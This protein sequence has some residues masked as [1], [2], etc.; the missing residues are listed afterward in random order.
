MFESILKIQSIVVKNFSF[1]GSFN[2]G[3]SILVID[4]S[5]LILYTINCNR[6]KL[7]LIRFIL[8]SRYIISLLE[9][10]FN[11]LLLIGVSSSSNDIFFPASNTRLGIVALLQ[12]LPSLEILHLHRGLFRS[13]KNTHVVLSIFI[14]FSTGDTWLRK[15][16]DLK[17]VG[18]ILYTALDSEIEPLLVASRVGIY[19]HK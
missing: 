2:F 1:F 3:C 17:G 7:L 12:R 10:L 15:V 16:H 14:A 19:L 13:N 4:I 11:P 8:I 5:R 9:G 6:R 18:F